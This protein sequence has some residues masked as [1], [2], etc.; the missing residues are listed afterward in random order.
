MRR[1][2]KR[3]RKIKVLVVVS[4]AA[5]SQ[6]IQ[7]LFCGRPEFEVVTGPNGLR[8]LKQQTGRILPEL[9]VANVRPVRTGVCE[10]VA[11]LKQYS[12]H[13]KLILICPVKELARGARQCGA[14]A[15]VEEEKLIG[16]LLPVASALTDRRGQGCLQGLTTPAASRRVSAQ[17]K[18]ETE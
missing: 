4:S 3:V 2:G 6:V 18:G 7:S 12:P 10:V 16:R 17:R 1:Q 14:D 11:S 15:C 9:I 5:L 8:N 13:S